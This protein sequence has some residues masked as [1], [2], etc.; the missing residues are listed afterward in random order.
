MNKCIGI[1]GKIFG[2]KFQPRYNEKIIP[3]KE[4]EA[5]LFLSTRSV[6][7]DGDNTILNS[8]KRIEKEYKGD[9]CVRCGLIVN[10]NK[11]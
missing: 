5:Q 6:I 7:L 3:P 11:G 1:F 9:V 10:E 4:S 8:L 2:H